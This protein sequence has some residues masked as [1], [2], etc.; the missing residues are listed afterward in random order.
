MGTEQE[1]F[2]RIFCKHSAIISGLI[3]TKKSMRLE[4]NFSTPIGR[5]EGAMS[6]PAPITCKNDAHTRRAVELSPS[7]SLPL[8][9]RGRACQKSRILHGALSSVLSLFSSE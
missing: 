9:S 4:G 7:R 3:P 8:A 1:G 2:L 5:V 6:L